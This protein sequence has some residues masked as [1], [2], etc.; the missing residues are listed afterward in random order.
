MGPYLPTGG[1]IVKSRKMRR[2]D[3]AFD[4]HTQRGK[5]S[6]GWGRLRCGRERLD[7]VKDQVRSGLSGVKRWSET[8]FLQKDGKSKR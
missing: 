2:A 3:H 5:F 7:W 4:I 8:N 1:G 6:S